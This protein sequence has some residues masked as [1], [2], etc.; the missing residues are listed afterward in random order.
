MADPAQRFSEISTHWSLIFRAHAAEN[1][2]AAG[3]RADLLARYGA[4]VYRFLLNQVRDP[5]VADELSQEFALRVLRGDFRRASPDR[6]HFRALLQAA[7]ANLVTDDHRRRAARHRPLPPDSPFFAELPAAE[8]AGDGFAPF[9]RDELLAH[10]WEGLA[11]HQAEQGG[12]QYAVLRGRADHPDL[13]SAELAA[14]L[15]ERLGQPL[16]AEA[17]RQTL[18]RARATFAELLRAEVGR[19]LETDEP[20]QVDREL[21][22]LGLLAYCPA[23]SSANSP[24]ATG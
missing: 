4:A 7:L 2:A 10:A 21:A 24:P 12:M 15:G 23:N 11:R 3:A 14:V 8:S 5:E 6:G 22:E 9:W 17:V 1:P 20:A 19:S 13:S 16:R 18:R